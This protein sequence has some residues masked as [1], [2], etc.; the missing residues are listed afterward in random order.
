MRKFNLKS[1]FMKKLLISL[2]ALVPLWVMAQDEVSTPQGEL[3]WGVMAAFDCNRA[4]SFMSAG[5]DA[6][7]YPGFTVG[8]NMRYTATD[9]YFVEVG[10]NAG[11][12]HNKLRPAEEGDPR[13]IL[14]RW[15]LSVPVMAGF[16]WSAGQLCKW[17]PML[18]LE[19]NYYF[20]TGTGGLPAGVRYSSSELWRP[21]DLAVC[22]GFGV[23]FGEHF[24]IDLLAHL[25]TTK[26]NKGKY[27]VLDTEKYYPFRGTIG[28]KYFF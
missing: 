5:F 23:T 8:G 24:E 28:V 15:R 11:F 4:E 12:D 21:V 1:K 17:R 27:Q 14:D 20:A 7:T 19:L 26:I 9:G 25:S 10:L 16:D 6:K 13:V 3:R 2:I 18:G 22:A